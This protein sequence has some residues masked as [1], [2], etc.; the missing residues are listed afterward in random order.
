MAVF[1]RRM[2]ARVARI[3]HNAIRRHMEAENLTQLESW[4]AIMHLEVTMM[5]YD[6]RVDTRKDEVYRGA[7]R[8][9]R[10][11]RSWSVEGGY[12]KS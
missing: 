4:E 6:F 8:G 12:S 10:R 1:G 7:L 9:Y 5:H 2:K 11:P 3:T